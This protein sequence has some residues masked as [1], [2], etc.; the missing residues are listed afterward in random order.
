MNA[1]LILL[2]GGSCVMVCSLSC[3]IRCW[4]SDM[5]LVKWLVFGLVWMLLPASG[6]SE[7]KCGRFHFRQ[8][9]PIFRRPL[10]G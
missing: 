7:S 4:C 5:V 6:N 1:M 10:A 3:C 2:K 9:K 8:A